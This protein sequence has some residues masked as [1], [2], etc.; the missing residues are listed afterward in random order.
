[1]KR[2][3]F[4]Q[5]SMMATCLAGSSQVVA[6]EIAPAGECYEWRTYQ[7]TNATKQ[8]R[9]LTYLEQAAM[10]AWKRIGVGPVGVFTETGEAATAAVHLLIV[11]ESLQGF[12][13]ARMALEQ[14]AEY[15]KA[16]ADYL[17][18][19]MN[20]PAFERIE[21]S[22]MV[23]FAGMPKLVV[24]TLRQRVLEL[25][26]YQSH[27]EA[28]ARRKI[29]MFNRGELPIFNKVG[30]E[31]VFFGETLIGSRLPNLKY[32]LAAESLEANK[33]A[34]DKFRVHPQ[35]LAMKDLPEYAETVS[36]VVQTYLQPTEFS[37]I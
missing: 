25:R 36:A 5:A 7:L 9:V 12:G 17:A 33:A 2:R 20:D 21:S 24:P 29:D 11:Y 18:A 15:Q 32:M 30:F 31:T 23:P 34:F 10:P 14:D 1:M 8:A 16:A 3:D 13:S 6:A 37:R 22:L 35:W 19:P 28:K 26:E 27:S 4:L